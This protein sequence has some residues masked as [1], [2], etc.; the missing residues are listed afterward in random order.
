VTAAAAASNII[1][2]LEVYNGATKVAQSVQSGQTF[3]AGATRSYTWSWPGTSTSGTYTVKVGVFDSTWATMYAWN[4]QAATVTVQA[5][6]TGSSPTGSFTVT[7]TTASP[8][9]VRSGQR[10]KVT[11]NV[12]AATA[13]S[14]TR[15]D[16]E[17]FDAAGARVGQ[18][19]CTTNFSA[20][21]TKTCSW[22]F[23]VSLASGAY[24]VKVGV[25][26]GDWATLYAWA[27]QAASFVV[28]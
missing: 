26:S 14:G 25:A 4:N 28:Q 24:T 18:H 17:I 3:T 22:S 16:L 20:G 19:V 10:L 23:K 1:V 8:T 6:P 7:S 21:Q 15:L 13:A 27:D 12:T 11:T 2:D 9:S 5:A